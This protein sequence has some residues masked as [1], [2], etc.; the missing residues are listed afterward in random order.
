M[1]R[2]V[3]GAFLCFGNLVTTANIQHQWSVEHSDSPPLYDGF[4]SFL[5]SDVLCQ[6]LLMLC[7]QFWQKINCA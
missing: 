2:V 7:K 1:D 6:H 5:Y 4:L 3:I